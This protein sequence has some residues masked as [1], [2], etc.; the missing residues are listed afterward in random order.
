MR[1]GLCN[2]PATFQSLVNDLLRPFIGISCLCCL[3][4]VL[5]FSKNINEHDKHIREVLEAFRKRQLFFNPTKCALYQKGIT[6]LGHVISPHGV[7]MEYDKVAAISTW[8][9]PKNLTELRGFLGLADIATHSAKLPC[10]LKTCLER[11]GYLN[12][13]KQ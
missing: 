5:I 7:G 12:G 9:T 6:F 10:R 2:A 3:D 11:T 13:Q 8:S 1:F 4:D